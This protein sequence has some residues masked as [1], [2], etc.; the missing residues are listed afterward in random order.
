MKKIERG[1]AEEFQNGETCLVSEYPLGEETLDASVAKISGRYPDEGWVLNRV[2]KEIAFVVSGQGKLVH[3][4][5]EE[6]LG[7]GDVVLLEP[8][9][10]FYWDGTMEIFISCAPAWKY[11]QYEHII[12]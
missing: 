11:A 10:K 12:D 2:S 1:D 7:K 3:E 5:G 6:T 8:G 9:E 4:N